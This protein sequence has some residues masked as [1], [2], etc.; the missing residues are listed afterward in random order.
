MS[1][2]HSDFQTIFYV[3]FILNSIFDNQTKHQSIT[4]NNILLRYIFSLNCLVFI[5]L[6]QIN[7][8]LTQTLTK[9]NFQDFWIEL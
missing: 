5:F 8:Q 9:K 3:S 7:D 6:A 2:L 1:M 4:T